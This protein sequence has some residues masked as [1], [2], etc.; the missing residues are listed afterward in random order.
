MKL[1]NFKILLLAF[2]LI[3]GGF[4]GFGSCIGTIFGDTTLGTGLTSLVCGITVMGG[5]V[6]SF[7]S[8]AII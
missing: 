5:L 8:G 3:D 4:I 7:T 1:R 2:F 6:S